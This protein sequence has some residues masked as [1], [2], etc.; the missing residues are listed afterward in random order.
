[1]AL[2]HKNNSMENR[3]QKGPQHEVKRFIHMEPGGPT[4]SSIDWDID[5]R[6]SYGGVM[7]RP[8]FA[9]SGVNQCVVYN[10]SPADVGRIKL[11]LS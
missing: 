3:N 4:E 7:R 9:L 6:V 11:F 5:Q 10:P 1:M 8:R 2:G